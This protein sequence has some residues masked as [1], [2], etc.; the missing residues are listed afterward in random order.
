MGS[1]GAGFAAA[2]C[3]VALLKSPIPSF[4]M[5]AGRKLSMTQNVHSQ[6][7]RPTMSWAASREAWPAGQRRG[8]CPSALLW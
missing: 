5:K 2:I 6:P 7:R 4:V 1:K 8:F 3:L